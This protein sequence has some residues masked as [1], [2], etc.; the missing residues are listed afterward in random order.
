MTENR[1][2]S[3]MPCPSCDLGRVLRRIC[4]LQWRFEKVAPYRSSGRSSRD[5]EK[6]V[7]KELVPTLACLNSSKAGLPASWSSVVRYNRSL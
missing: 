6:T 3:I 1:K 7:L 5:E 4:M 2:L